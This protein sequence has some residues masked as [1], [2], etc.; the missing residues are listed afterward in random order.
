MIFRSPEPA[1][2][3]PDMPL[4]PFLLER[5]AARGDKPAIIDGSTGR[6]IT[7]REWAAAVRA[8]AAGLAARG[9]RKGEVFA[10]WSP[11]VPEYAIAFHAVS[12]LGA[13]NTTMNPL[14]TVSDTRQQ[15]KDAGARYLV[16]VPAC[17]EKARQAIEDTDV[18]ELIVFGQAEGAT[19]FDSLLAAPGTGVPE[20]AIDP[21]TD[22]VALPYSSGTTGL[23]KGVMLTHHNL[24]ANIL[25]ASAALDVREDDV[26]LGVLPFFH[27]YGMLV[28]MNLSLYAGAPVV[29]LPRFDLE[30]CLETLQRYRV[31]FAYFVPPIV[32]ALAKSPLVERY[33]LRSLRVIFSG[34]APLG[35]ELARAVC[36]RLGCRLAQ[37]YGLTETSPVTHATRSAGTSEKLDSVGPPVPNTE[38][39]I[40]DT[41]T[42]AELGPDERGEI[43]VR[44][45]QVMKGYL[46]RPDATAAMIDED[47][48]LHSGDIGYADADGCFF[49]VDRVK[50]LIKFKGLQVAPAEL[51]AVLLTHP[52][53][54]DAAVVPLPHDEAGQVPKAFVVLK[55]N[56]T[57][58]EII[59]YVAERVAP[60]KKI[61][62]VEFI[63]QIPKSASGKILRRVLIER[64]RQRAAGV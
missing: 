39:K 12:L 38:V 22:L 3:V 49:I 10:I 23:P 11:N 30:H 46:N 2:T 19:P 21:R 59:G 18:R 7:C 31:T 63:D 26:T 5:A 27:I 15:L 47:G 54:A 17:L 8:A 1:L 14:N 58:D 13:V 34:A 41:A 20:A 48:W 29:T 43:C 33:D 37:G 42:G 4:T 52:L 57:A 60:Y 25:Q 62:C 6:T 55:G 64:D 44:G 50:E 28:I 16:T 40:V 36:D 45:P 35:G 51:E 32:L 53:V 9:L 61:R 56:A 24:V